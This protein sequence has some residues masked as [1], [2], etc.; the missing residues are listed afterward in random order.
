VVGVHL[1]GGLIG[2]LLLGLFADRAFN[3]AVVHEGALIDG[4]WEL[5]G[6]QLI[7]VGATLVWSAA[8]TF[9]I[10]KVLHLVIPGGLRV[11]DEDE[12]TGLDLTQHSETG[13]AYDRV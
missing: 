6:D 1:A 13:Y 12:Q 3:P 7:A 10:L 8:L 5:M 11:S 4:S 9:V 2:S